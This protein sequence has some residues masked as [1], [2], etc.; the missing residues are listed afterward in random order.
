[1]AT[2]NYLFDTQDFVSAAP[3]PTPG[4]FFVPPTPD[5]GI[6]QPST[7]NDNSSSDGHS[8]VN[9]KGKNDLSP[10]ELERKR[11]AQNR[12]AQRAF[13][14]RKEQKVRELESKLMEAQEEMARLAKE[15]DR[16][17]KENTVMATKQEVLQRHQQR[18]QQPR[19]SPAIASFPQDKFFTELLSGHDQSPQHPSFAE[20]D[21]T[22]RHDVMLGAGTVW[23]K[24]FELGGEDVDV[25]FVLDYLRDKAHCDGAGPVYR[26][27]QLQQAI[28]ISQNR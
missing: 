12:A 9:Y 26:L 19:Q 1:M 28:C 14:E 23:Q 22:E 21:N 15:N 8:P 18:Q 24:M 5:I 11:K 6:S 17:K 2:M 20:Y 16:L 7:A 3:Q 4:A 10:E 25:E 27:S 13:R